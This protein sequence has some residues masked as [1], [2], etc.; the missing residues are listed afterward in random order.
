MEHCAL[1]SLT[2]AA[3]AGQ[4][5]HSARCNPNGPVTQ[6]YTSQKCMQAS[7][8]KSNVIFSSKFG[9]LKKGEGF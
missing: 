9:L 8:R 5:A 3:G 7:D 2:E 1:T 6:T 4:L